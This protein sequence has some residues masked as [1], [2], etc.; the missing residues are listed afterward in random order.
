LE[1]IDWIAQVFVD[2]KFCKNIEV[3]RM[4]NATLPPCVD[5]AAIKHA[6]LDSIGTV[7][8]IVEVY[9][10]SLGLVIS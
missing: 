8:G 10:P 1:K 9:L 3:S 5:H 4:I 7:P 6:A 2:G